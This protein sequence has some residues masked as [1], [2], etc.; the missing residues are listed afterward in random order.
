MFARQRLHQQLLTHMIIQITS[1][2]AEKAVGFTEHSA[3]AKQFG[4]QFQY[5][6]LKMQSALSD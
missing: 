5:H 1:I 4:K 6:L 2:S 3:T